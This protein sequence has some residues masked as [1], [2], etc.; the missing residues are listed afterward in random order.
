MKKLFYYFTIL[1]CSTTVM[2][3]GQNAIQL[4]VPYKVIDAT[5][6]FYL[7]KGD[8]IITVKIA[9]KKYTFKN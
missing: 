5:K 7:K 3:F 4:S 2:S 9:G 1:L 8:E 6:K